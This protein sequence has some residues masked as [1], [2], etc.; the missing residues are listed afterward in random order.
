VVAVGLAEQ[1]GGERKPELAPA[2]AAL[3]EWAA[4]HRNDIRRRIDA[5]WDK[6]LDE[7]LPSPSHP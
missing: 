7:Q 5:D 2:V 1:L 3:A 6:L 4:N